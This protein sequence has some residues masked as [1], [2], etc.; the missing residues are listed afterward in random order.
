MKQCT[1][2]VREENWNFFY[3]YC[4]DGG[5]F[6]MGQWRQMTPLN[7]PAD[8]GIAPAGIDKIGPMI[9]IPGRTM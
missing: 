5:F 6:W 3:H 8:I 9:L 7:D 2:V 1:A 4:I